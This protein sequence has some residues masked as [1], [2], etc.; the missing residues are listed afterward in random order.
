[1]AAGDLLRRLLLQQRAPMRCDAAEERP[2]T[3]LSVGSSIAR[4]AGARPPLAVRSF[5]CSNILPLV[6]VV[7]PG[8]CVLHRRCRTA[9]FYG[10]TTS[11]PPP[12]LA[13]VHSSLLDRHHRFC[14]LCR[15][16]V[17]RRHT[18]LLYRTLRRYK[19]RIIFSGAV[20]SS[21]HFERERMG[22]LKRSHCS[23]FTK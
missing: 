6:D 11:P 16:H 19:N 2:G 1:M 13:C 5:V 9:S 18:A 17:S 10:V 15:R 7:A 4:R 20:E 22:T 23:C 3:R 21:G 14:G 12:A 8:R